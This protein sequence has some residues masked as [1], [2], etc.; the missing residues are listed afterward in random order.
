[1][2]KITTSIFTLLLLLST[3]GVH[4]VNQ[5]NIEIIFFEDTSNRYINSE[6]WP[7]IIPPE[8]SM[9]PPSVTL[10][11][12]KLNNNIELNKTEYPN[13]N[14]VINITHHASDALADYVTRLN[15]SSRYNVL[16][17]RSWQQ[18]G[19]NDTDAIDIY[20]N[21]SGADDLKNNDVTIFN[22]GHQTSTINDNQNFMSNV[23]GTLKLILGRYLHIH[24]DLLYR[25]LNTAYKPDSPV[26]N[27]RIFSE[28]KIK[29]QRRMRSNELHYIDHPL[30][31]ILILVSPIKPP[32]P[33]E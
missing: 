10:P 9:T 12:N 17:H 13:S 24:T 11:I 33:A 28:Y 3:F 15:Q 23:E 2:K 16:L 8:E 26:L 6:Q 7:V 1:M 32:E 18:T 21:T 30:L 5:Y 25:R 27:G 14:S 22:P 20:V 19:L 31:G 4:A 29:S